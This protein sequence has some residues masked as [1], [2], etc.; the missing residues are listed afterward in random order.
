MLLRLHQE[1]PA[2]QAA[3]TLAK[4]RY[5]HWSVARLLRR[6]SADRLRAVEQ[7]LVPS[8]L[9]PLRIDT[10]QTTSTGIRVL[11]DAFSGSCRQVPD[12]AALTD[13]PRD[14]DRACATHGIPAEKAKEL[15][16]DKVRWGALQNANTRPRSLRISCDEPTLAYAPIWLGYF[17]DAKGRLSRVRCVDGFEGRTE[18]GSY[19]IKVLRGLSQR[20][21]AAGHHAEASTLST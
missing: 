3:A 11:V 9:V 13:L 4:Q 6:A 19:A 20:W 2:D 18:S 5:R 1:V 17:K 7:V 14:I 15:A 8:W 12:D 21:T 16:L 10:E